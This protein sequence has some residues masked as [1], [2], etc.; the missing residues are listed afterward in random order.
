MN[1]SWVVYATERSSF[2]ANMPT[3]AEVLLAFQLG[4]ERVPRTSAWIGPAPRIVRSSSPGATTTHAAWL[5]GTEGDPNLV[6]ADVLEDLNRR[7]QDNSRDWS[8]PVAQPFTPGLHG[9]Q[10]WW[11]SGAAANTRSRDTP[12][13]QVTGRL[14]ENPLGPDLPA[15]DWKEQAVRVAGTVG[16]I[17]AIGLGVVLAVRSASTSRERREIQR[18]R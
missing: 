6:I 8:A 18:Y 7:L 17:A 11:E 14:N 16:V 3:A 10:A 5:L 1:P 2:R 9:S 12:E 4:R 13:D 15:P